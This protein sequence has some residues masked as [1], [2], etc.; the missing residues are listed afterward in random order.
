MK[1]QVVVVQ[2]PHFQTAMMSHKKSTSPQSEDMTAAC[3][4]PSPLKN[5]LLNSPVKE[6]VSSPGRQCWSFKFTKNKFSS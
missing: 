4:H 5:I 6:T 1:Q 2:D 3:H